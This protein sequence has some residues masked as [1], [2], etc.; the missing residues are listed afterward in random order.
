MNFSIKHFFKQTNQ[1]SSYVIAYHLPT[2]T[3]HKTEKI[4]IATFSQKKRNVI[5]EPK[6]ST[7]Y[8]AKYVFNL[9]FCAI[10]VRDE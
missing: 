6:A 2:I 1:P 3:H 10:V 4:L 5:L 9:R 8:H 7:D